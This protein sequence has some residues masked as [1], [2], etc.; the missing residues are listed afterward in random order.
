MKG[1]GERRKRRGEKGEGRERG[2]GRVGEKMEGCPEAAYAK[3]LEQIH[4]LEV[5]TCML[6]REG[7]PS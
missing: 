4:S 2:E 6:F 7:H 3:V 5:S 1:R